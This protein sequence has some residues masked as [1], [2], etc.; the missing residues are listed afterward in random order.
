MI[1]SL[2]IPTKLKTMKKCWS[3]FIP[4]I[5]M[6]LNF[7]GFILY[8]QPARIDYDVER[9]PVISYSKIADILGDVYVLS[10]PLNDPNE[11]LAYVQKKPDYFGEN[12]VITLAAKDLGNWILENNIMG[13]EEDCLAKIERRLMRNDIPREYASQLFSGIKKNNFNCKAIAKELIWLSENLPHMAEGDLKTYLYS[14]ADTQLKPN[15]TIPVCEAM[16]ISD[17]EII[18]IIQN[19]KNCYHQKMADQ[20]QLMA[21]I[22]KAGK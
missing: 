14:G 20:I 19:D 13:L 6:S 3:L 17:P 1:K 11:L 18:E 12:G 2:R 15:E 10:D 16:Q 22:S 21:L 4:L 7:L 9:F 5:L 8:A